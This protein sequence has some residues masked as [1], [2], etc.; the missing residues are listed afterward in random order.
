MLGA[1]KGRICIRF[2]GFVELWLTLKLVKRIIR[3][4]D[5]IIASYRLFMLGQERR[6]S[7]TTL[8]SA[9]APPE[10]GLHRYNIDISLLLL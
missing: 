10:V 4:T 6:N 5:G 7:D 3:S 2:D 9:I 1:S 8:N